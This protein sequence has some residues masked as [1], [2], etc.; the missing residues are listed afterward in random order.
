MSTNFCN[1]SSV[2]NKLI[3]IKRLMLIM[4]LLTILL[5]GNL[6]SMYDT[7]FLYFY[8]LG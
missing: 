1:R 3:N 2:T 6:L 8:N 5:I 4:A 7:I